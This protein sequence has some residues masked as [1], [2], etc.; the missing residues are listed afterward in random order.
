VALAVSVGVGTSGTGA[1]VD[2]LVTVGVGDG[3]LAS[4]S[5][6]GVTVVQAARTNAAKNAINQAKSFALR[7]SDPFTDTYR[8]RRVLT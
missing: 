7:S 5:V 3:L 8:G 1:G 6:T 4:G 2:E